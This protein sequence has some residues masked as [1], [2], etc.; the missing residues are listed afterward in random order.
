MASAGLKEFYKGKNIF[1]TGSTGFLGVCLLEK[2]LR[3]IPNH[4]DIY[5]LLRPKKGKQINERLEEIKS[6]NIFERLLKDKPV[7]EVFA[8]VK[9]VAG[10]VGEE[11]L[12]LSES[13]RSLLHQN[14][15]VIFHSA[16][17]L[18]FGDDLNTTININLL[19]TRRITELAK[20][21]RNLKVLIHVS[22]AYVNSY[23]N[24]AEEII[25][26]LPRDPEELIKIVAKLNPEELEKQTPE[27]LG[28]HPNTYTITKHMAEH[29]VQKCEELFPCTIVRPSMIVGAFKEP[30]PGW[31]ISKNG[32]QGFLMGASKGVI[33]RLP[34]AKQLIYDY[35][36]VDIV[37][38]N[39][40]AAG[41]HSG[42]TQ[43]K[44]TQVYHST[45]STRNPFK[46]DYVETR[47][48]DNLHKYPLKSAVWYPHL[49]LLP[50]VTYYKISALFVHF[51]PAIIL[52]TITRLTGGRPILMKL[53]R[54]VNTSLDR[55]EKFIFTEWKFSAKNTTDLQTWLNKNDQEEFSLDISSLVW[56][57]YFDD[58]T[59]GARIYL[60][61]DP[62][63]TLNSA[64]Q[65]DKILLGIHLLVQGGI[66]FLFWYIFSGILGLSLK[67]SFLL[68]PAIVGLLNLL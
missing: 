35:I 11:N 41:F 14:V 6:N 47:I 54:N 5:L 1:I 53:H 20:K 23:L 57:A 34:V 37:V 52:D 60:S 58:L 21:C 3:S 43:S 19:G 50:S 31:T 51:L 61:K 48:N 46:W 17:T 39:L 22:S 9:A 12:G 28:K 18:D 59:L 33:R 66:V 4:G 44:K 25:Y 32:P 65:K 7:D 8:R 68:V 63:K 36:P 49:K 13:D 30:V 55:L 26:P 15:N 64:R 16:A 40:L 42:A 38:N 29:E 62:V 45:S 67:Q 56:P 24:E 2:I 27:L 10:D